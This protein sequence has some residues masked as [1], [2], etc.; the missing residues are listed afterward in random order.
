MS[1]INFSAGPAALPSVV[2]ERARQDLVDFEGTGMSVIE[3][4]HR[5][6]AYE[7]VQAA[8]IARL[9]ELMAVPETHDVLV[10][11]GGARTQ[12]A[13]LPMNL[14]GPGRF[15]SYVLTGVWAKAAYDE[16]ALLG[17][18]RIVAD[19]RDPD[20]R[21][22]R[23]PQ[24]SELT[25]DPASAYVHLCSN[26][27]VYG[28][29]WQTYPDT[30]GVPL[31]ADMTSDI[32]SRKVD[33]S[34]FGIIYAAAQKNL[35]AAGAVVV[36]IRK[37]LIERSRTDIPTVWRYATHAK[38]ASLYYTPATFAVAIMRH[39]LDHAASIGGVAAIEEVNRE[40]ARRL[41]TALAARPD[42]YRLAAN[43]DS[44]S[45]MNVTFYLPTPDDDARFVAEAQRRG[46]V[47]LKGHRT[48]GGIRASIYNWVSVADVDA[49]ADLITTFPR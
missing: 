19:A 8:A 32:L 28:T 5:G 36:I 12:F 3:Q 2:V 49:L 42:V 41:Y 10:L 24:A 31:V 9:R 45:M 1:K 37:D 23:V 14:V 46:M 7:K 20:G 17:D 15:A 34:Q 38:H 29:Q 27:T 25:I 48:V 16:A 39:V 11:Q 30:G 44:R 26:N 21:Y 4:S 18:A 40:K 6:A 22:R 35:G 33:V 43:E 47:G 13:M